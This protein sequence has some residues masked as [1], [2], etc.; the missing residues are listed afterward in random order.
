MA[1]KRLTPKQIAAK[2]RR[3]PQAER[4]RLREEI[5]TPHSKQRPDDSWKDLL[6]KAQDTQ[7]DMFE[8]T[9]ATDEL[10]RYRHRMNTVIF[11]NSLIQPIYATA[12]LLGTMDQPDAVRHIFAESFSEQEYITKQA[13]QRAGLI[14]LQELFEPVAEDAKDI[15]RKE[16]LIETTK[17]KE[18]IS[19]DLREQ[20]IKKLEGE[21]DLTK[22][23]LAEYFTEE[24]EKLHMFGTRIDH[25]KY[26]E[27]SYEYM[28]V[29]AQMIKFLFFGSQGEL[30]TRR[31]ALDKHFLGEELTEEEQKALKPLDALVP[32]SGNETT[33]LLQNFDDTALEFGMSY[34]GACTAA[35]YAM[36]DSSRPLK[37]YIDG[38]PYIKAHVDSGQYSLTAAAI[39]VNHLKEKTSKTLKHLEYA[40]HFLRNFKTELQKDI[41]LDDISPPSEATL[42]KV[43]AAVNK[44]D[45]TLIDQGEKVIIGQNYID[46]T[47]AYAENKTNLTEVE[48]NVL[49]LR[50]KIKHCFDII[51]GFNKSK[52]LLMGDTKEVVEQLL[53]N[54]EAATP[55]QTAQLYNF[56]LGLISSI[57]ATTKHLDQ[58]VQTAKAYSSIPDK[59]K[60]YVSL[61]DT[62]S[63]HYQ[64]QRQVLENAVKEFKHK[65]GDKIE[66]FERVKIQIDELHQC[67]EKIYHALN[68]ELSQ[69]QA[70]GVTPY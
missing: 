42:Q 70:S 8:T 61:I 56:T 22:R 37:D 17:T 46:Q 12:I 44:L 4:G 18:R 14:K 27:K 16:K 3:T 9:L 32:G 21:I 30:E 23:K 13:W 68:E 5:L 49:A 57:N 43:S 47:I 63:K 45:N 33:T 53:G 6:V 69:S 35:F 20:T 64:E 29:L 52:K 67:V 15:L 1:K 2:N 59:D 36:K 25:E 65:N 24:L 60:E 41:T 28:P 26:K 66:P 10:Q 48:Q 51:E 62:V 50:K 39:A 34:S 7:P 55:E 38:L 19:E 31:S 11:D 40:A 54:N 58:V